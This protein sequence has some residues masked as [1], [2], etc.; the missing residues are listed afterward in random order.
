MVSYLIHNLCLEQE[1][2]SFDPR[3][4][5]EQREQEEEQ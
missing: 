3:S 1:R 4:D 5:G 2:K